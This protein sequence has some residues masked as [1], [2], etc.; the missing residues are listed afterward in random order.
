LVFE[1]F[2]ER[3]REYDEWYEL[4]RAL[5]ESELKLVSKFPCEKPCLEVG[6][7]TGRF[8]AP[9]GIEVGLDPAERAL[10][11]AAE[12][13]VEAVRGAAEH[14]PFRSAAFGSVYFI[15]TICF[16]DDAQKS[17]EEAARAL[18][19]GG[20]LVL[21]FVPRDSPWGEFYEERKR[22]GES[23]FYAR[24]RFYAREEVELMLEEAGFEVARR[25]ST[26]RSTKPGEEPPAPEEPAEG[27]E[28]SFVCLEAVKRSEE[29]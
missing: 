15:V 21:C 8:A 7:G 5:Y 13:G 6:V 23:A 16:V 12:R 14:L 9:L 2:E 22:R 1:V 11:Y 4:H 3:A 10:R 20:K 26:L 17:L 28:G 27:S 18:R 29:K 24:A 19:R 25:A